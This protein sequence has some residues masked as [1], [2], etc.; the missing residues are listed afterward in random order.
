MV[1][2]FIFK[3]LRN[4]IIKKINIK[5]RRYCFFNDMINIKDFDPN[6]I[7][8]DEKPYNNVGTYHIGYITIKS[9]GDCE[10]INSVNPLYL[11]IG[12]VD[13]Y[14]K[15]NIG[16]KYLTFAYTEKNKIVLEKYTVLWDEIKYHFQTINADKSG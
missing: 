4:G 8:I 14:I 7:K 12:E 13:G 6:L 5:N 11:M 16:N 9:I 1:L 15:E 3:K 10:N 2:A